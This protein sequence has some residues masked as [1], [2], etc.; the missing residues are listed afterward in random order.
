MDKDYMKQI[1]AYEQAGANLGNFAGMLHTYHKSLCEAGFQRDE[2][3]VLV[4]E[5]QSILFGQAFNFGP[6]QSD[7]DDD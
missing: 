1:S 7:E 6:Q 2:A 3:L 5:L 4:K